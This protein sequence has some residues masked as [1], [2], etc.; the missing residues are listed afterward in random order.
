MWPAKIRENLAYKLVLSILLFSGFLTLIVTAIQLFIEYRRDVRYLDV[1]FAQIEKSFLTPPSS[2]LWR[3]NEDLVKAQLDGISQFRDIGYAEV[4]DDRGV[5]AASGEKQGDVEITATFPLT[6]PYKDEVRD[7]G[8]LRVSAT[9][10]GIYSRLCE[11]L[12]VI[13]ASSAVKTFLTSFFMLALFQVL[14]MRH[15]KKIADYFQSYSLAD[16][17]A[18]LRLDIGRTG[19]G[20]GDELHRIESEINGLIDRIRD[21]YDDAQELVQRRTFELEKTNE[22]LRHRTPTIDGGTQRRAGSGQIAPGHVA[23]LRTL[24][25]NPGRQRLL[26]SNRKLHPGPLRS[27]I[28][29]QHL[30]GLR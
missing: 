18:P 7:L 25:A 14:V 9:Y 4:R 8:R 16:G 11:R 19:T 28:Q 26:E 15:L 29:P 10:A 13:L 1:Q 17:A 21:S 30:P 6:Y 22:A 23:D 5:V 2:A 27:G 24:Q 20:R 3:Y 12:L